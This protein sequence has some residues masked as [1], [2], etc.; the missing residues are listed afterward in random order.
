MQLAIYGSN[1][2]TGARALEYFHLRQ[3]AKVRVIVKS[4]AE[5]ASASRFDLPWML[6]DQSSVHSMARAVEGCDVLVDCSQGDGF[7]K[8]RLTPFSYEAA[9]QAGIKR[10]IFVSPVYAQKA[11][12]VENLRPDGHEKMLD[13]ARRSGNTEL[14]IL[15]SGLL[16]GPR[17]YLPAALYGASIQ[18]F[19]KLEWLHNLTYLDN[20][21]HAV[22][23]SMT[24]PAADGHII[25]ITDEQRISWQEWLM[26]LNLVEELDGN[27]PP[28]PLPDLLRLSDRIAQYFTN[29]LRLRTSRRD[30]DWDRIRLIMSRKE[31]LNGNEARQALEYRPAVSFSDACR[32]TLGWL[33][34]ASLLRSP[35]NSCTS[36]REM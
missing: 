34:F 29:L 11:L 7:G 33:E 31:S 18:A 17:C 32:K 23:L 1:S 20:L 10:A 15:R 2:C 6:V 24:A 28:V 3:L 8:A 14:V 25:W 5:L 9:N 12:S 36:G 30:E 4:Y 19:R 13:S 26:L 22:H 35:E 21:I 16:Y 27:P